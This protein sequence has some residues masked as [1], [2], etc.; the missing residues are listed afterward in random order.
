M[1]P[2]AS[3]DASSGVPLYRQIKDILRNEIVKG[4]ADPETPITEAQLL[5]RFEVSRAPI[6]Q[7]LNE[8][9]AEGF[10]YRKQGKGTFPIAGARVQRPANIRPGALYRYLEDQGLHPQSSVRKVGRILP[11][12]EVIQALKLE[13]GES[14][15]HFIRQISVDGKT[16]LEAE[17]YV[18]VPESFDPSVEDLEST[19]SAFTL[20]ERDFGI[21][22]DHSANEVW[23]TAA[24]EEQSNSLGVAKGDPLMT[25]ETIFYTVGGLPAGY[26]YAVHR[27]EE[28]KYKFVSN[29]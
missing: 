6:R 10:V 7:A 14:L 25:I 29:G 4:K 15:L 9:V 27:A 21:S 28:F 19:G 17:V 24:T 1:S 23:A 5:E 20:L 16:M 12:Q 26:R 22:L 11:P 8:L 2:Q 18:R 13:S 3:I